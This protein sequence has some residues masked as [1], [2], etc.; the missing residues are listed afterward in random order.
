MS[1]AVLMS[2]YRWESPTH[3][4]QSLDSL[5]AQTLQPDEV[6]IVKDGPLTCELED[7]LTDYAFKLPL[8]LVSL[9]KNAGLGTA[10]AEG[11]RHCCSELVARMDTDDICPPTRLEMQVSFMR[12]HPDCSV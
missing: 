9:A 7:V 2:T 5:V 3:L 10:L 6:I 11:L 1:I 4:R 8:V 12:Q